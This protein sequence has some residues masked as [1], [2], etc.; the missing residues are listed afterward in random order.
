MFLAER[1]A[2]AI[3]CELFALSPQTTEEAAVAPWPARLLFTNSW[4][5]EL[6]SLRIEKYSH[7]IVG[8]PVWFGGP[9]PPVRRFLKNVNFG[10]AAVHLFFCGFFPGFA[11][12]FFVSKRQREKYGVATVTHFQK[13]FAGDEYGIAEGAASWAASIYKEFS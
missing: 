8:T 10:D 6:S 7:I 11:G 13:P 2:T 9:T 3:G 4:E 5:L 1:M 12:K